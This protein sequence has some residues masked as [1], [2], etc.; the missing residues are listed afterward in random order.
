MSII[1]SI[2]A[3]CNQYGWA[4]IA[5]LAL[6][7]LLI[8]SM[9][10]INKKQEERSE[11]LAQNILNSLNDFHKM[12]IDHINQRDERD[13]KWEA[14]RE[15]RE[16]AREKEHEKRET[17][18]IQ[19]QLNAIK[20]IEALKEQA[21]EHKE[22]AREQR[23]MR[24]VEQIITNFYSNMNNNHKESIHHRMEIQ[25]AVSKKLVEL[26]QT[27][28][29]DRVVIVEFHNGG[30]N[31]SGLSFMHYDV[32]HEKQQRHS[33][34]IIHRAQNLSASNMQAIINDIN[35]SKKDFVI[36]R[37]PDIEGLYDRGATVLYHDLKKLAITSIGYCA[38][39]DDENTLY[40]MLIVGWTNDY[41]YNEQIVNQDEL[42]KSASEIGQ[43]YKYVK[44]F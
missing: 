39:Y 5:I 18:R 41:P 1:E 17:E 34:V 37:E 15:E 7:V 6:I 8:F 33:D 32:T 30:N 35:T 22:E 21:R 40:A 43:L 9:Q 10:Y 13:L 11:K 29:S 20:E 24:G 16:I 2:L 38:M 42:S 26:K 19:F 23:M 36:Y 27:L 44:K 31:L 28:H 12:Y 4:G 14:Q 25:T 3:F